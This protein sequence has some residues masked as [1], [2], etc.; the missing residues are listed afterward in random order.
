MP[1]RKHVP[2]KFVWFQLASSDPKRAQAFYSDV[3]GWK[4]VRFP[5]GGATYEMIFAGETPDTMVGDYVAAVG[6]SHWI[7]NVSVEDVDAAAT[8]ALANGGN[9][10]EAP[11]DV[12]GIGRAA[13]I[14]DPDGAE[15]ALFKSATGDPPD[16]S[17]APPGRFI[18]NELHTTDPDKAIAFYEK[19]V[20]FSHRTVDSPAGPYHILSKGG[21]DRGGVTSHLARGASPYWM[22]IV[23]VVDVDAAVDR[24]QKVGARI[25]RPA[26]DMAGIGRLCVIE[27]PTG[28]VLAVMK[29]SPRQAART[30]PP[31]A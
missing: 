13:K 29:P 21:V 9:V 12:P 18:W 19:V 15:L 7:A 1:D 24:A 25:R 4:A 8:A 23:N 10:L 30:T 26:E 27:D 14:A 20:G 22:P 2:G 17:W 11:H 6:I 28:A 16:V 5:F 31:D 3:L